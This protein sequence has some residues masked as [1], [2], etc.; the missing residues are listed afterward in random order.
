[1]AYKQL[2]PY[3]LLKSPEISNI[4]VGKQNKVH[5]YDEG[6]SLYFLGIINN[7]I[8]TNSRYS[9]HIKNMYSGELLQILKGHIGTIKSICVA[10]NL[11]ISCSYD[12]TIRVWDI[13]DVIEQNTAESLAKHSNHTN[14]STG[15][16]GSTGS[17]SSTGSNGSNQ[18]LGKCKKYGKCVR[19]LRGHT[20]CVNVINVNIDDNLIISGS[21][22]NTIRIWDLAKCVSI[23]GSDSD[24]NG[25]ECIQVLSYNGCVIT[26]IYL[27]YNM[28]ICGSNYYIYLWHSPNSTSK[29][30]ISKN[31]VNTRCNYSN[32]NMK[33]LNDYMNS[34]FIL[35]VTNKLFI[36]R[37]VNSNHN[38]YLIYV[39]NVVTGKCS[40]NLKGHT[41]RV[42]SVVCLRDDLIVSGSEDKTIRIWDLTRPKGD[43]CIRILKKHTRAIT[44][45]CTISNP[46][47]NSS[48]NLDDLIISYSKDGNFRIWDTSKS[49]DDPNYAKCIRII[50]GSD[51]CAITQYAAPMS[52]KDNLIILKT[53]DVQ[54]YP[55][56][57]FPTECELFQT[58]ICMYGLTNNLEREIWDY[59]TTTS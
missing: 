16:N 24:S 6:F 39:W 28:I 8:I 12:K 49:I 35:C 7:L 2:E 53:Y 33:I 47:G 32:E 31:T 15:S 41:D 20:S 50:H 36:A 37:R 9:I 52:V 48:G 5:D 14:S 58:I 56:T 43:E 21:E 25:D 51:D 17:N 46:I 18:G 45:L 38:L 23:D 3:E 22:D 57:L 59:M 44:A 40:H 19:V 27:S 54:L 29:S 4:Y 10:N 30:N 13:T 34:L 1:M 26:S 11:I 42:T 55:I